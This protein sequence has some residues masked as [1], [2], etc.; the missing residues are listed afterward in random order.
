IQLAMIMASAVVIWRNPERQ[1]D[2]RLL[3]VLLAIVS[4]V[5]LQLIPLP[6]ALIDPLQNI[7]ARLDP[8]LAPQP[9]L[10]PTSLAIGRTL[11]AL[12]WVF[13][14]AIYAV[15]VTKLRFEDAYG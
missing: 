4:A 10:R 14:C 1:T 3:L 5:A 12:S 7:V 13:A 15:A 11:D 2:R 9:A 8:A 6:A